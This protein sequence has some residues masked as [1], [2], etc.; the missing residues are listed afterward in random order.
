MLHR[1]GGDVHAVAAVDQ[2]VL[3]AAVELVGHHLHRE[4]L[5][6]GKVHEGHEGADLSP[7][8]RPDR[9]HCSPLMCEADVGGIVLNGALQLAAG[10]WR[11]CL[12]VSTAA[13]SWDHTMTGNAARD[14]HP[15]TPGLRHL[16]GPPAA[17]SAERSKMGNSDTGPAWRFETLSKQLTQ[18]AWSCRAGATIPAS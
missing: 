18:A 16:C 9:R 10:W 6:A 2:V 17:G 7:F 4:D 5:S 13:G 14:R 12:E 1:G 15:H 3:C 8:C 11:Y